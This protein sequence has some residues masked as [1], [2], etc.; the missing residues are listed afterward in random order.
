MRVPYSWLREYCDPG[1]AAEV[2]TSK[3]ERDRLP[4]QKQHPLELGS[5]PLRSFLSRDGVFA[6]TGPVSQ[7]VLD[8]AQAGV[9]SD[10]VMQ[11]QMPVV[12]AVGVGLPGFLQLLARRLDV[13]ARQGGAGVGDALPGV[14]VV[15]D[16]PHGHAD[17]AQQDDDQDYGPPALGSGGRLR[18]RGGCGH[19]VGSGE[20]WCQ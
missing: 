6:H 17:N 16:H 1:I 7:P 8:P 5:T 18:G 2:E 3:A 9:G 4:Q 11:R 20:G 14:E 15:V 12:V 10:T 13:A 19:E